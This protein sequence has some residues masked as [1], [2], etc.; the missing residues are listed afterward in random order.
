MAGPSQNIGPSSKLTEPVLQPIVD[1][2]VKAQNI[3]GLH[4][5]PVLIENKGPKN[6]SGYFDVSKQ[7]FG[8]GPRQGLNTKNSFGSLRDT[9]DCFDTETGLWENEIEVVK[10]FVESNTRPKLEDYESWSA[11]MKKYYD[12]LTNMKEDDEVASETDETARFMKSGV[13]V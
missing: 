1:E 2:I 10:K 7:T 11:N 6:G 9:E 12:G 5:D 13:K 3:Y 4:S 8:L